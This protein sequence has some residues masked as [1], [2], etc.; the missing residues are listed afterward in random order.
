MG[1]AVANGIIQ[2]R[3]KLQNRAWPVDNVLVSGRAM[4]IE[5]EY[6]G[7]WGASICTN[8]VAVQ[9]GNVVILCVKPDQ[10]EAMMGEIGPRLQ[11]KTLISFA[12]GITTAQLE[13]WAAGAG[14]ISAMAGLY[15]LTTD[16]ACTFLCA[17]ARSNQSNVRL[18][19]QIFL[20][21]GEV[22]HIEESQRAAVTTYVACMEAFSLK[23]ASWMADA[24]AQY[25]ITPQ[26]AQRMVS[27]AN[28]ATGEAYLAHAN[29][30]AGQEDFRAGDDCEEMAKRVVSKGGL[31]EKGLLKAEEIGL[32]EVLAAIVKSMMERGKEMEGPE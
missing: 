25:G 20:P 7:S 32:K 3:L 11:G 28:R 31:T 27:Y 15:G 10:V 21:F 6:L 30:P 14:V 9:Y 17:G 29:R 4:N 13:T 18:A 5:L 23:F 22:E 2:H 12:A 26:F 16:L 8:Q 19:E 24:G 1:S